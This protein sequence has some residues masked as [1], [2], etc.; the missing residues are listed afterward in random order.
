MQTSVTIPVRTPELLSSRKKSKSVMCPPRMD[1]DASL[2]HAPGENT[3]FFCFPRKLVEKRLT[4]PMVFAK[5]K[6]TEGNYRMEMSMNTMFSPWFPTGR[7]RED[8][9]K[10]TPMIGR[11]CFPCVVRLTDIEINPENPCQYRQV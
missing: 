11:N 8:L 4:I 1:T 5:I 3:S 6:E 10:T 7:S 9:L 2:Y